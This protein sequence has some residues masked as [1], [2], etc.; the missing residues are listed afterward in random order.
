MSISEIRK[1]PRLEKIKLME[2]LWADLSADEDAFDSPA[3]HVEELRATE[4]RFAAGQE[5]M[6]DWEQAKKEL[7][8]KHE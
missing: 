3:W 1:M 7:R 4:A 5:E 2:A 6:L 8:K